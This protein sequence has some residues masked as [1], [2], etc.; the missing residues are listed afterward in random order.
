MGSSFSCIAFANSTDCTRLL[1]EMPPTMTVPL[2]STSGLS[3]DVRIKT[4]G[5]FKIA[6]SSDNVP[7]RIIQQTH[8]FEVHYSQRSQMVLIA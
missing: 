3:V 2:S 1:Y 6:D 7:Y 5:N 4:A 8:F